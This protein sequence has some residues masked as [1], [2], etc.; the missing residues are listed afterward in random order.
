MNIRE[1]KEDCK[2]VIEAIN[3]GKV[4]VL[5]AFGPDMKCVATVQ[6]VPFYSFCDRP[7]DIMHRNK[8]KKHFEDNL[9]NVSDELID[10]MIDDIDNMAKNHGT[11]KRCVIEGKR[12]EELRDTIVMVLNQL[13]NVLP[14][15]TVLEDKTVLVNN[16]PIP[17][18]VENGKATIVIEK[19]GKLVCSLNEADRA[20]VEKH[21]KYIKAEIAKQLKTIN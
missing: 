20:I 14:S 5:G 12:R 21:N 17:Y 13:Y 10:E 11:R 1:N 3:S 7:I 16:R 9:F 6:G 2:K 4:Y 18:V 19:H 15:V 8:R